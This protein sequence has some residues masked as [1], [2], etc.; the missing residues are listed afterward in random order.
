MTPLPN[1]SEA[2]SSPDWQHTLHSTTRYSVIASDVE[3]CC[4]TR[5][6]YAWTRV[7]SIESA[8]PSPKLSIKPWVSDITDKPTHTCM[9]VNTGHHHLREQIPAASG[10]IAQTQRER[11]KSAGAPKLGGS[12]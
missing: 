7:C 3:M 11:Q 6:N 9:H 5:L 2:F 10:G 4:S 12:A 8:C 1:S